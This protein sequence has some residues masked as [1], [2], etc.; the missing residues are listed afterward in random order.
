MARRRRSRK[1]GSGA[2]AVALLVA[3]AAMAVAPKVVQAAER[4]AMTLAVVGVCVLAAAIVAVTIMV[5]RRKQSRVQDDARVLA[6]LRQN[7]LSPK[8]FEHALAA[9]CR[10]D[11]CAEVQV[12]GGAGDLGADVLARAPDGRR[13]VLQ[14]KR[15]RH[16][17]SVGSQDVQR[18]G[19]T[20]HT[21]HRAD[22]AAVVT[23]AHTF[24]PQAR[25]YA[26]K[27]GILLMAARALAAWESQ[28]GPAPWEE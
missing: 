12:V 17:R 11:G 22:V 5:R 1:G 8:E 10:R 21:I 24:T 16:D 13:V 25:A 3:V 26:D 15:Y 4:Q 28:T 23:T 6:A 19:G 18:F 14:A 27:A 2:F 9:L 7:E 20:A